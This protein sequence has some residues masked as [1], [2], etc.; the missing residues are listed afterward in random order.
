M[1]QFGTTPPPVSAVFKA[2][3]YELNCALR[4]GP[5]LAFGV[6]V[7]ALAQTP[8]WVSGGLLVQKIRV[9]GWFCH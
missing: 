8:K 4:V 9:N 2:K 7:M 3:N 1:G 6:W 5:Q